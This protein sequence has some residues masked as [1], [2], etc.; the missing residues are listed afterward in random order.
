MM[1]DVTVHCIS[2]I[3]KLM[4]SFLF[5]YGVSHHSSHAIPTPARKLKRE[6]EIANSSIQNVCDVFMSPFHLPCFLPC[7]LACFSSLSFLIELN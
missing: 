3:N 4:C 6:E 7:L 2:C 1:C 5:K